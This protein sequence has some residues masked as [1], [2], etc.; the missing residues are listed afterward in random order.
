MGFKCFI[1]KHKQQTVH[2]GTHVN[3]QRVREKLE[4]E[5]IWWLILRC[6]IEKLE[7]EPIWWLILRCGMFVIISIDLPGTETRQHRIKCRSSRK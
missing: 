7:P 1:L 6:G 5:P 3:L 4:P 2:E